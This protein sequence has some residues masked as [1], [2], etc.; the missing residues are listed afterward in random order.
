L[1]LISLHHPQPGRLTS[2][3]IRHHQPA[4][5]DGVDVKDDRPMTRAALPGPILDL[6]TA[7]RRGSKTAEYDR[8]K[9]H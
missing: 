2:F 3:V 1:T 4:P 6:D 8:K 9:I 5:N 7:T